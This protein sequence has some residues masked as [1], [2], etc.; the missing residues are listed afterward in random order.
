MK[1]KMDSLRF[2]ILAEAK[3]KLTQRYRKKPVYSTHYNPGILVLTILMF[4]T[5]TSRQVSVAMRHRRVGAISSLLIISLFVL[6]L[7]TANA[8]ITTSYG[9]ISCGICTLRS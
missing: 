5:K 4:R 6:F 2:E 7:N 1:D 3:T 8:D 9:S